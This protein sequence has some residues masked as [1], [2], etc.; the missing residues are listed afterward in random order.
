MGPVFLVGDAAHRHP[1][2]GGLGLD[3]GVQDVFN[4]CWKLAAVIVA[5]PATRCL[6]PTRRSAVRSPRSTSPTLT[7]R[8]QA[9]AHRPGHGTDAGSTGGRGVA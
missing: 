6:I 3:T 2:T 4:L 1:P 8:G 9:P 5:M 7:E